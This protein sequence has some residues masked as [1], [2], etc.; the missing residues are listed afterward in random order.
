MAVTA[1]CAAARTGLANAQSQKA[2]A[3]RAVVKAKKKLRAAKHSHRP[4]RVKKAKRVLKKSLGE[5]GSRRILERVMRQFQST[6]G[7]TSLERADP[8]Q[9]GKFILGEHPQTIALILA[10]LHASNA[11]QLASQLPEDLRVDVLTRMASLEDISPE[12][13]TRISSV[14]E[15]RLRTLGGRT[16]EVERTRLDL[17]ALLP[18]HGREFTRMRGEDARFT[19]PHVAERVC[20]DH[21]RDGVLACRVEVR[22]GVVTSARADDPRLHSPGTHDLRMVGPDQIGYRADVAHHADQTAGRPGHREQR[23]ARV[24]RGAG[25]DTDHATGV[26]LRVLVG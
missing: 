26:L 14:I 22:C 17:F 4:A 21:E 19:R 5:E 2:R 24:L 15:A 10:H 12:V 18:Q 6:V 7:F 23:G 8:D 25:S 1:E 20:V 3:H 16:R 9:L 11:A 13:V